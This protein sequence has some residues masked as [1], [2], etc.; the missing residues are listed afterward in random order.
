MPGA[1]R[2]EVGRVIDGARATGSLEPVHRPER[3]I[4]RRKER[5]EGGRE[6]TLGLTL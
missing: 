4:E 3:K 5:K 6:K 2:M 1:Y